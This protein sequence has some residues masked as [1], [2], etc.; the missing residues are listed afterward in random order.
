MTPSEITEVITFVDTFQIADSVPEMQDQLMK[1][2]GYMY[3]MGTLVNEAE[4]EYSVKK[5]NAMAELLNREDLTETI[6]K[7]QLESW[8]A[9]EKYL[10]NT[11]KN[12]K[13][14]LRSIQMS[15]FQGIK[16]RNS[17]R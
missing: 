7:T 16:I 14:S 11:A 13:Q 2:S 15:L 6:R 10:W 9:E 1:A 4:R 17:E 3:R 12:L 5:N 8:V